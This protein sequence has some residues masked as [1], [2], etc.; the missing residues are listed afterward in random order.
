MEVRAR[1]GGGVVDFGLMTEQATSGV[2]VRSFAINPE[3]VQ[4]LRPGDSGSYR[5]LLRSG[6]EVP[7]SRRYRDQVEALLARMGL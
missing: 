1:A 4:E 6:A 5:L 2:A 3:Q 7:V